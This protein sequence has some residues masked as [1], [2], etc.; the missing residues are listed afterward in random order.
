MTAPMPDYI[1]KVLEQHAEDFIVPFS[2]EQDTA[3][4][5]IRESFMFEQRLALRVTTPERIIITDVS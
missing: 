5:R 1:R 4:Y 3:A 2:F